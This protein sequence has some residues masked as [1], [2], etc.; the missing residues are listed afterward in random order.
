MT[1]LKDRVK[2]ILTTTPAAR[3][4][5]VTLMIELWRHYHKEHL[6]YLP[7]GTECVATFDLYDLPRED[8]IK[9]YRAEIQNVEK[10]LLPT[11]KKILVERA[12][13][14]K[15]WRKDLGYKVGWT[16]ADWEQALDNYLKEEQYQLF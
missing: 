13:L 5:D 11:D 14:S 16:L 8:H 4:S 7:D 9:R 1:K 10:I 6:K 2:F 3:N 12:K 15:E